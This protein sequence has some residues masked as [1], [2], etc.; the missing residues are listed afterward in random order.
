MSLTPLEGGLS[1][2]ESAVSL[3]IASRSPA[4]VEG[5]HAFL[6]GTP[7]SPVGCHTIDQ[8]LSGVREVSPHL[9]I[10]DWYLAD[11]TAEELMV[12]AHRQ[13]VAV[14]TL[15][16]V[17]PGPRRAEREAWAS[18]HGAVGCILSTATR[19]AVIDAV[20]NAIDRRIDPEVARTMGDLVQRTS[21]RNGLLT[22]QERVVLRLMRQQLTYKEIALEL[23]VSW[24]TIRSHAQSI[25][26]KLGV[27]SRRDLATW[28]A[29][30]GSTHHQDDEVAV[31]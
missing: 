12:E 10:V 8:V 26:R 16:I 25:L 2:S 19:E 22:P 1:A 15:M 4:M 31:A 13:D 21:P 14:P 30:L 11:G 28:D 24:H 5:L 3:L 27:H 17:D 9:L 6:R 20:A 18:S 7:T 29:R 23:S